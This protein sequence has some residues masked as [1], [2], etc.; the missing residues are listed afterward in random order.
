MSVATALHR[1]IA[2]IR[3]AYGNDDAL[4]NYWVDEMSEA[5]A[6]ALDDERDAA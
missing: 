6:A 1:A 2:E 3:D 4:W 5:M